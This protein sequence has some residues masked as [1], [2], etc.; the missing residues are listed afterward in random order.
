MLLA[1]CA[2]ARD[3]ECLVK[4]EELGLAPKGTVENVMLPVKSAPAG[5][6][7]SVARDH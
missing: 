7:A 1:I 3:K 2:L 4:L 5:S 6:C